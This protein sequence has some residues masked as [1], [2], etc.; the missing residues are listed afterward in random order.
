MF[1]FVDLFVDCLLDNLNTILQVDAPKL[2]YDGHK[3]YGLQRPIQMKVYACDAWS[4]AQYFFCMNL[5]KFKNFPSSSSS[6]LIDLLLLEKR[7]P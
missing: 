2:C 6:D 3:C 4:Q 1:V 7:F 5:P